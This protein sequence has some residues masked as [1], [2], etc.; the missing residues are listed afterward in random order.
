LYS[1]VLIS[2]SLSELSDSAGLK[3]KLAWA[4]FALL[5]VPAALVMTFGLTGVYVLMAMSFLVLP[6]QYVLYLWI[7]KKAR[8][9]SFQREFGASLSDLG[10]SS[11][12]ASPLWQKQLLPERSLFSK[13]FRRRPWS[14]HEE[15][16]TMQLSEPLN[17]SEE[18]DSVKLAPMS[19]ISFRKT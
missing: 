1:P 2:H 10:G 14:P 19:T 7:S 15:C 8:L 16:L 17:F 5:A 3:F 9:L 4:T 6:C 13:L 18:M 12:L 11:L